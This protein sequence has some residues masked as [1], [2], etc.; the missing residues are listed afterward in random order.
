MNADLEHVVEAHKAA[1]VRH[2]RLTQ[3]LADFRTE[4]AALE[5]LDS[6]E[7][8]DAARTLLLTGESVH[9]ATAGD[10]IARIAA[11]K[12]ALAESDALLREAALAESDAWK[13]VQTIQHAERLTRFNAAA[14]K[15]APAKAKFGALLTAWADYRGLP[16][17]HVEALISDL[18]FNRREVLI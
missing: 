10:R 8:R 7:R 4:L 2:D 11:I 14:E 17:N 12:A 16:A 1:K 5:A 3:T 18:M 13:A 15:F 9:S 6:A